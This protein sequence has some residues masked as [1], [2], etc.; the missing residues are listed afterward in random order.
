M[1]TTTG[2]AIRYLEDNGFSLLRQKGSHRCYGNGNLRITIM[3]YNSNK[4]LICPRK[5]K[6]VNNIVEQA[7]KQSQNAISTTGLGNGI[8]PKRARNSHDSSKRL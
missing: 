3:Y 7:I 8:T 4:H 1:P 5:N 6:E 2:E